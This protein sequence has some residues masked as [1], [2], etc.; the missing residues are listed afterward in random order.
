MFQR[1][2]V[3]ALLVT[4]PS[5]AFAQGKARQSQKPDRPTPTAADFVYGHD[6]PRQKFDFWQATSDKPTPLVLLIHGG[7]WRGGDKSG[8]GTSSIQPFLDKGI[9]VASINYRFIE[10]AMEQRR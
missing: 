4:A 2:V 7:G 8:Y 3:L 5:F 1:L 6:S 9:S 10:Q